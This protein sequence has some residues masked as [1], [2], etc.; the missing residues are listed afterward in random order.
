VCNFRFFR[1]KLA[2]AVF[3]DVL[4]NSQHSTRLTPESRSYT[5]VCQSRHCVLHKVI[6]WRIW[7]TTLKFLGDTERPNFMIAGD[8]TLRLWAPDT[9]CSRVRDLTGSPNEY[10]CTVYQ[11]RRTSFSFL[12]FE[13]W[14]MYTTFIGKPEVKRLFWR[15]GVD[16]RILKKGV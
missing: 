9:F 14:E 10:V 1:V 8:S 2:T 15:A 7:V 12:Y 6:T 3:A 11:P 13:R 5:V 4:D 16:G